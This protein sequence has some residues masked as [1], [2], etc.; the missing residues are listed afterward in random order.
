MKKRSDNVFL[1]CFKAL[2]KYKTTLNYCL[3]SSLKLVLLLQDLYAVFFTYH[4]LLHTDHASKKNPPA[5]CYS[6]NLFT[7]QENFETSGVCFSSWSFN[8][9]L[10]MSLYIHTSHNIHYVDDSNATGVQEYFHHFSQLRKRETS[11][12]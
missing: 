2:E 6:R 10:F 8:T 4:S 9:F 1:T 11:V 5:D 3:M 12:A 7:V